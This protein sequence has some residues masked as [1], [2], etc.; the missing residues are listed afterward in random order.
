MVIDPANHLRMRRRLKIELNDSKRI[1]KLIESQLE[2]EME[3]E[4]DVSCNDSHAAVSFVV[5]EKFSSYDML[6]DKI[7]VYESAKYYVQL[8][9][10]DSRTLE[11]SKKRVPCKAAQA[12]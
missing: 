10:S 8:C 6:K 4:D 12:D 11:A 9:H 7:S 3:T 1:N 2:T 5:G